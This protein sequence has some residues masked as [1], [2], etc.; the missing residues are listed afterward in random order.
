MCERNIDWLPLACP[1]FGAWATTNLC[2]DRESNLQPRY[3]P[4]L[5]IKLTTFWCTGWSSNQLSHPARAAS[6]SLKLPN[7]SQVVFLGPLGTVQIEKR[8]CKTASVSSQ[9]KSLSC[10]QSH[11]EGSQT[12]GLLRR[13]IIHLTGLPQ[14]L[15]ELICA[16]LFCNFANWKTQ[17]TDM[18]GIIMS[19]DTVRE[20]WFEFLKT[21]L[22]RHSQFKE[23]TAL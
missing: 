21:V 23:V 14:G 18:H 7:L 15:D 19:T 10:F 6:M 22:S 9:L 4:W 17:C 5:G 12:P 3:I 11:M 1:Q 16:K 13:T 20:A 2:A 8:C